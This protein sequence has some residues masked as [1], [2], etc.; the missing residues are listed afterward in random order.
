MDR[1]ESLKS[2]FV[3]SVAGGLLINGCSPVDQPT[4]EDKAPAGY[5]RSEKEKQRD[6]KLYEEEYLN[7]HELET[8]AILCDLI[9]PADGQLGSAT[10]AGVPEF[11]AFIV[12]DI[13]THQLPIRGGLMWLDNRANRLF[14]KNFKS[15]EDSQMKALC[16]EIAYPDIQDMSL[17]VGVKFFSLIRD[18][19]LTGYYTSEMGIKD[20]GYKGNRPNVWDGVPEDVLK[21]HGLSYDKEW[22]EKCVDQGKRNEIA[23]W[24]NKGNLLST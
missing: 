10:D 18:L 7:P 20:L 3:G 6:Q 15:L 16:D 13:P 1:R 4:T 9:L 17:L 23:Q 24:D 2:L 19:T 12:K 21:K 22:L 11:V 8:I 5:G 14:N